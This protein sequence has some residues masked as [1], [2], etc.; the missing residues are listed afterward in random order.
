MPHAGT[1]LLVSRRTRTRGS[2]RRRSGSPG[3]E[4]IERYWTKKRETEAATAP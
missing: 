1:S 3:Q 2:V 4:G